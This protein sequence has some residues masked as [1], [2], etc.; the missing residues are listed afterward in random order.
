MTYT[1]F[2]LIYLSWPLPQR[3]KFLDWMCR[4]YPDHLETAAKQMASAWVFGREIEAIVGN[5]FVTALM[6][7]VF[8]SE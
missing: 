4:H 5:C 3:N 1:E 2:A 7:W 6:T 8:L